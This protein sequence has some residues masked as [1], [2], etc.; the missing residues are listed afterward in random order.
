M[1]VFSL[2]QNATLLKQQNGINGMQ[3]PQGGTQWVVPEMYSTKW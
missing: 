1:S 3:G 2:R